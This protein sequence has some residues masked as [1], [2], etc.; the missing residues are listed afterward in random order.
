MVKKWHEIAGQFPTILLGDFSLDPSSYTHEL[1][2][3]NT[4]AEGDR[5]NFIDCWQRLG[6]SEE[7]VGTGHSYTGSKSQYSIDWTLM[8]PDFDVENIEII[9]DNE[10]GMY[11]RDYYPVFAELKY[12]W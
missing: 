4:G 8:T 5:G 1:F 9:Y 6:K 11:P 2:C 7:N 12:F 3:E 10:N